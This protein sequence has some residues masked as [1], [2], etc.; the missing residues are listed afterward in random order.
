MDFC[1]K[2]YHKTANWRLNFKEQYEKNNFQK[3]VKQHEK[4]E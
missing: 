3:Q 4:L 2:I 1:I